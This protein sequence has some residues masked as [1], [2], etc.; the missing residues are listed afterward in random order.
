MLPRASSDILIDFTTN[1]GRTRCSEDS[2][3]DSLDQTTG[4]S[5]DVSPDVCLIGPVQPSNSPMT[6]EVTWKQ[7]QR[8]PTFPRWLGAAEVHK[9]VHKRPLCYLR[10]Q[11]MF[12]LAVPQ[13]TSH[14]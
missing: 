12:L 5:V 9:Q 2:L 3:V 6:T 4:C 14:H 10:T 13:K 11:L 8:S 1:G 7:W